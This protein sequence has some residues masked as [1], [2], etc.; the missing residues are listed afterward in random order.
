MRATSFHT[1]CKNLFSDKASAR[2]HITTLCADTSA[3][4]DV[5]KCRNMLI[6]HILRQL[7]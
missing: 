7:S 6:L 1:Y 2:K 5:L 3:H 4:A